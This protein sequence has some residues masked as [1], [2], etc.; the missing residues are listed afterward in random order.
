MALNH[1]VCATHAHSIIVSVNVVYIRFSIQII[2]I[3][4]WRNSLQSKLIE[5]SSPNLW[6][7]NCQSVIF[8]RP[9]YSSSRCCFAFLFLLL[10]FGNLSSFLCDSTEKYVHINL[11]NLSNR[12]VFIFVNQAR[13]LNS[14]YTNVSNINFHS[15]KKRC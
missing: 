14:E 1:L 8:L 2:C 10:F 4:N 7:I 13:A 15:E 3:W 11:S 9:M 12:F 5:F 6:L